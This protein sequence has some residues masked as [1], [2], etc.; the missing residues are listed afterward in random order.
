ML[1][2]QALN[3]IQDDMAERLE[4]VSY[5]SDIT[6]FSMRPSR[7]GKGPQIADLQT[8]LNNALSGLAP[9]NGKNGAAVSVLMP[10][11]DVPSPNIPGPRGKLTVEILAQEIPLI[12]NG[13]TGTKKSCESIALA[14]VRALHL[15]RME[16]ATETFTC[17]QDAMTPSLE[18]APKLTYRLKFEATLQIADSP[19]CRLPAIDEVDGIITISNRTLGADVYY[20]TDGSFPRAGKE[21]ASLYDQPF[22]ATPGTVIRWAAYK[23]GLLG[24]DVGMARVN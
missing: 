24:S 10:M 8:N 22:A 9:K 7:N 3:T 14:V 2:E 17:S 23:E 1:N 4:T 13:A 21:N 18:F 6:I 12:N 20:T 19:R 16:G 11:F 15:F 5:F